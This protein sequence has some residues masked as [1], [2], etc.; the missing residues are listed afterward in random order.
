MAKTRNSLCLVPSL[1]ATLSTDCNHLPKPFRSW[2]RKICLPHLEKF[3]YCVG[4]ILLTVEGKKCLPRLEK[5]AYRVTKKVLDIHTRFLKNA[6][7]N[8]HKH[9]Q[10]LH[11]CMNLCSWLCSPNTQGFTHGLKWTHIVFCFCVPEANITKNPQFCGFFGGIL[12]Y[13][14]EKRI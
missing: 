5:F 13:G 3:A 6:L 8:S 1:G 4:K 14:G 7:L 2:L 10:L 9:L 11:L 12:I